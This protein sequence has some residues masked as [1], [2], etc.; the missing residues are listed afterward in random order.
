[1]IENLSETELVTELI[2]G[3]RLIMGKLYQFCHK[4]AF[5]ICYRY[6]NNKE[7][8]EDYTHEGFLRVF[9]KIKTFKVTNHLEAW[10]YTI[11]KNNAITMAKNDFK[12]Y[13]NDLPY[14]DYDFVDIT[15][16]EHDHWLENVSTEKVVEYLDKLP[17]G[18]SQIL[19]MYAI[20]GLKHR[21]ISQI[22]GITEGTSKSQLNKGRT[23]LIEL[24]KKDL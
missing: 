5:N 17:K 9:N 22:L 6:A 13:K 7:D 1:M 11:I 21:E 23:R 24:I 8:A 15:E 2:R 3:N 16:T 12:K 10:I 14:E 20:E 4:K 18:A 19:K